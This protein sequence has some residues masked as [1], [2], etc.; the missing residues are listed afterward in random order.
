MAETYNASFR[1][2][3]NVRLC[4]AGLWSPGRVWGRQATACPEAGDVDHLAAWLAPW[5][6]LVA[7]SMLEVTT[8]NDQGSK[9]M[10][11]YRHQFLRSKS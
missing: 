1:F 9:S 5:S 6:L 7:S 2:A 11:A 10:Q 4:A 3:D 8:S